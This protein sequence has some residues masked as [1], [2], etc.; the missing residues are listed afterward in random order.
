MAKWLDPLPSQAV[1]DGLQPL[2][3]AES[4][5]FE[6]APISFL[7]CSPLPTFRES[8]SYLRYEQSILAELGYL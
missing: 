5:K 4:S 8:D 2:S 1:L 3:L 6:Q 7:A